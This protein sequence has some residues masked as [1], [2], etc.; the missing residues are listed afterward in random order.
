TDSGSST[1]NHQHSKSPPTPLDIARSYINRGWNPIPVPLREKGP[2]DKGWQKRTITLANVD[3]YFDTRPQNVGVQMGPRSGDLADV[4]LD[5]EEA[6]ALAPYFLPPTPAVFGR[7]SKPRSHHLYKLDG[8]PNEAVIQFHD[9]DGEMIVEMRIGGGG[10]AA[11]TVFPG[12]V[13]KSD[14][15]VRWDEEGEPLRS[16]FTACYAAVQKIASGSLLVRAWPNRGSRHVGAL[17]LGGFLARAGW[18]EDDIREF[19]EAVATEAGD[20]EVDDRRT[21]ATD[22]A[23]AV[24]RGDKAYGLPKFKEIFGNETGNKVAELF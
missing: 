1:P 5:C 21:A 12:S 18:S 2:T 15:I 17:A 19:V 23:A 11:Q 3:R 6:I 9:P 24:A 20:D 10:K 8:V 22:S 4:D 13:H 14:E 7:T 16:S